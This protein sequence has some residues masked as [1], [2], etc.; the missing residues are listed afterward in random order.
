VTQSIRRLRISSRRVSRAAP[1]RRAA[2]LTGSRS[3]WW[4][5][6]S[7]PK[8]HDS[9]SKASRWLP[10]RRTHWT[11]AVASRSCATAED[12]S[13]RCANPLAHRQANPEANR[14]VRLGRVAD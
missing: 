9:I 11:S 4:R 1:L 12:G 13:L 6:M 14:D 5:G 8:F 7:T 3:C 2:S 10:N